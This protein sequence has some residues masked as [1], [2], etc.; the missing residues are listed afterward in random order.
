MTD[1]LY[2]TGSSGTVGKSGVASSK[3][4]ASLKAFQAGMEMDMM[5]HGYDK[6]LADLLKEGKSR[7]KG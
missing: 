4:E 6:Y 2:P 3:K 5:S 7:K 1:L